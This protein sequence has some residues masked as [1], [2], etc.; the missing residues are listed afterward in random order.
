MILGNKTPTN[1]DAF[2]PVP[3]HAYFLPA[4]TLTDRQAVA[5]LAG[6]FGAVGAGAAFVRPV[7]YSATKPIAVGAETR[8]EGPSPD[9]WIDLSMGTDTGT[10]LQPGQYLF[11]YW[12]GGSVGTLRI[13]TVAGAGETAVAAYSSSGE[14]PVIAPGASNNPAL[15]AVTFPAWAP[16][17]DVDDIY[18]GRLAWEASQ[19]AFNDTSGP[20]RKSLVV[21]RAGWHGVNFDPEVG[22]FAI[23]RE[24]G[25]CEELVGR[26]L[27][28]TRR[29][30]AF[31]R[32]ISVYCY[33]EKPFPAEVQDEDLSL[34]RRAFLGISGWEQ[35][36]VT[37]DLEVMS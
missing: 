9:A 27:R 19:R 5:K 18:L 29:H 23:A 22:A 10:I 2:T 15:I 17:V 37:V 32:S 21:A 36:T 12:V 33:A 16:P 11:G 26:R 24:G 30:G 4:I 25:P 1:P 8:I 7:I 34:T 28:V 3:G 13:A 6:Y 35:D 14:P 20:Q 31:S